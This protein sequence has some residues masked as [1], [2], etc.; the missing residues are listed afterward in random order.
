MDYQLLALEKRDRFLAIKDRIAALHRGDKRKMF[1][2]PWRRP[3]MRSSLS[4]R[5]RGARAG[6]RAR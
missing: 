2:Q 5:A 4:T 6:D 3:S 1:L